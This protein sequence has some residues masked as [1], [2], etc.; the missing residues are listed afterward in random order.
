MQEITQGTDIKFL[1]KIESVG[2]DQDDDDWYIELMT[3]N[4]AARRYNKGDMELTEDGWVLPI[5]TSG[6]KPTAYDIKVTAYIADLDFPDNMR[7]EV[8]RQPLMVVKR[9]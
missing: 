3:G 6:L 4:N 8:F 1:V 2:F 5:E 9:G 7:T